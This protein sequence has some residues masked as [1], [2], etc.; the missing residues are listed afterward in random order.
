MGKP[1]VYIAGKITGDPDYK[2]KF[3][4]AAEVLTSVGYT[5]LSPT[6]LPSEGFAYE[7][8]MRMSYAMLRECEAVCFLPSW[9]DSK[10]AL[11]EFDQARRKNKAILNFVDMEIGEPRS[12]KAAPKGGGG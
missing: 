2:A 9:M 5:V 8:Y 10:G 4:H 12:Q 3:K 7:A 11:R 1:T 6:I